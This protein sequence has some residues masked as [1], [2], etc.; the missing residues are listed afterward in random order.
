VETAQE[1]KI[2][3][4]R[5]DDDLSATGRE[6][7][8]GQQTLGIA[9]VGN[10]YGA[11]T[12]SCTIMTNNT[13]VII[14]MLDSSHLKTSDEINTLFLCLLAQ[15]SHQFAGMQLRFQRIADHALDALKPEVRNF[16]ISYV[17]SVLLTCD[18]FKLMIVM[19]EVGQC[20]LIQ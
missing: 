10:N 9:V 1:W 17:K 16:P 8:T 5:G 12:N 13:D 20:G 11:R 15:C 2:L 18:G 3:K 19:V 14:V 6:I 4:G 7:D